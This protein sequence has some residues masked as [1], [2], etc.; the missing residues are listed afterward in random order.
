[1]H[2]PFLFYKQRFFFISDSLLTTTF[3]IPALSA[4]YVV[5]NISRLISNS[6][7]YENIFKNIFMDI[8]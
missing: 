6:E 3:L 5:L 7:C 1:M 2:A 8:V 4:A